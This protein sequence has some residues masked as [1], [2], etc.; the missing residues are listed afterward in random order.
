[1]IKRQ[2][3]H[4]ILSKNPDPEYYNKLVIRLKVKVRKMYNKI[5]FGQPYQRELKRLSK[6]LLVAKKKAQETF[7]RSVLQ[8][9]GRCWT[10]LYKYGKRRKGNRENIPA[11]KDH[12]GT[13]I[14][15][16]LEKA[17]SL[18]YYYASLLSCESNN[19]VIQPTL[20]GK[21]FPININIIRKRLSIIER[22]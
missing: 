19:P 13:L 3:P 1:M 2:V 11:I 7:L 18:K 4:E 9:E 6:E 22:M 21:P 17:N 16:P 8:N 20:S 5:I 15:D 12:N 14:T 10:E